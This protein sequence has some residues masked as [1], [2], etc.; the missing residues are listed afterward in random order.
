MII[1]QW[2]FFGD[3]YFDDDAEHVEDNVDHLTILKCLAMKVGVKE[4]QR[5]YGHLGENYT[6]VP[7]CE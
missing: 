3:C 1:L 6:E 2:W 4:L 5:V 7:K